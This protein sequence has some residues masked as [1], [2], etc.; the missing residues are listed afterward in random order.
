MPDLF[1]DALTAL[2]GDRYTLER[3]LGGGG[4]SRV[5]VATEAALKREVVVKVLPPELVSAESLRRFER[6]IEMTVALQHP[7]ILP[8][9]TA[10]GRGDILYYITPF[11]RGQSLRRRLS[12]E[13][14]LAFEDAMR[15]AGEVLSAVAF[16]HARGIVHRDIKPAN[17]LIAE[18]HAVLADFGIA[19]ALAVE[20]DGAAPSLTQEGASGYAAPEGSSHPTSDLFAVA[21]VLHE[22]LVG[23]PPEPGAPSAIIAARIR[24]RHPGV[25]SARIERVSRGI[26]AALSAAATRPS[27]AR[28]L[29]ELLMGSHARWTRRRVALL[30][31]T[32]VVALVALVAQQAL[33][34]GP[35]ASAPPPPALAVP[36]G[37]TVP[38]VTEDTM[39]SAA[40][41]PSQDAAAA[42]APAANPVA[43]ARSA[44]DSA[45]YLFAHDQA[46]EALEMARQ[47]SRAESLDARGNLLLAMLATLGESPDTPTEEPRVAVGRALSARDSLRGG[48][49]ALADAWQVLAAGRY[50]EAAP[51]FRALTNREDVR[52][53]ALLGLVEAIARDNL[54]Q[55]SSASPSGYAFRSDWSEGTRALASAMRETPNVARDY[56]FSRL[57][58][59][60]FVD[61]ARVRPG[62]GADSAV[63]VGRAVAA[64]DTVL[65]IPYPSGMR[66]PLPPRGPE[67]RRAVE[68]MQ[69]T[70]GQLVDQW[71]RESPDRAAPWGLTAGLLEATGNVRVAGAERLSAI[72][73]MQ[74]ARR[75]AG[76][77]EQRAQWTRD[78]SRLLLRAGDF[79]G[80]SRL[81]DEALGGVSTRN[82]YASDFLVP[83]AVVAGRARQGADLLQ[84]VSG[85]RTR[86][87]PGPD[88]TPVALAPEL[89]RERAGF[90]VSAALGLC[91]D[92]VRGALE[93]I[94][95]L[96]DAQHPT[97]SRPAG[98]EYALL[99]EPLEQAQRCVGFAPIARLS[100]PVRPLNR[101]AAS[102]LAG[103]T[104]AARA[105]FANMDR[106][107]QR[108]EAPPPTPEAAV[109][110]ALLRATAGDTT[111]ALA[112]LGRSL[113]A[114]PVQ[115][116]RI[117]AREAAMGAIGRGML[118]LA[119]WSAARDAAA[120][121]RRLANV[122]ALWSGADAP[123]RA[124]VARVR[125][126]I[127]GAR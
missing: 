91:S 78:L 27:N 33:M 76:N 23:E 111:G 8:V 106:A 12:E 72:D 122:D 74:Q 77:D 97:E 25:T 30:A 125:R 24:A 7:H 121:R 1:L 69:A 67:H 100:G 123:L 5:F 54:V 71:R 82:L 87:L 101:A 9:L 51:R 109:G 49:S 66:V 10:G 75:L 37:T 3:E 36:S 62:R 120:A 46:S 18:G 22:M 99:E 14:P 38:A 20:D 41:G 39:L 88:G 44:I 98:L 80:V 112:L 13:P 114:L 126:L 94:T 90:A 19:R 79:A 61:D 124:E 48:E 108:P 60:L 34:R 70:Y 11:V 55:P 115:P 127:D 57:Q 58:R 40:P 83:V 68:L 117:F 95:A 103:D 113:D 42:G 102:L 104:A 63:F 2:L 56:I 64:G 96:A 35:A 45:R 105:V 73:A 26:A 59:M 32:A 17:V 28:A 110:E 119:E 52:S 85:L 47:A 107:R 4:M 116:T 15:L 89:S 65:F 86:R 50:A 93:R 84:R 6:E 53:W 118:L 43:R 81:A 31:T 92:A 21:A 29:S 16:A